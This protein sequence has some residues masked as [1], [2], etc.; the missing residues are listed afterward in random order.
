MKK[1]LFSLMMFFV[2]VSLLMAQNTDTGAQLAA[3]QSNFDRFAMQ[4]PQERVYL[5]FDN[6]SYYK[7]EHIWYKAYVV[8]D[9]TLKASDMSQILY[10]E[11][12]NALGYPVETQKLML[13][14]G[15]TSGSFL[16]K[17]SLNAGF[18]EVRAYTTWMLNFAQGN[19]HGW[20]RMQSV[21]GRDYFAERFLHYLK[22]NAGIFSRV[23][24]V[25]DKVENHQYDKKQMPAMVKLNNV[26]GKNDDDQ[27]LIDFYPEGGNL[28]RGVPTRVAFQTHT[29]EGR[30][31]NVQGTLVRDGKEIGTFKTDHAGRGV[32]SM[33]ANE[34]DEAEEELM[35]GMKLKVVY[36]GKDYK[37]SLPKSN[38]RGYVLNVFHAGDNFRATVARNAD[39]PGQLLGINITSRGKTQ[40]SGTVDL[41]N[42]EQGNV[43]VDKGSLRTGVNIFTLY[44][45]KGKVLAQ[46]Q[47]FVNNHDMDGMHLQME[48]PDAAN[49]GMK[50]Y[51]KMTLQCQVVDAEGHP[52]KGRNKFS[53][54]VTD[55]Q[56][57]DGTYADG[58]MLTYL[59]LSSEVKGFIPHPEYY[60]EKE[61]H[62]HQTALDLLLMVQGWTRYDFE[63]MMSSEK[64]EPLMVI[65]R[66]LNFRGR[67]VENHGEYPNDYMYWKKL[68]KP[69]W[70][71][72]EYATPYNG[73][74]DAEII[75]DSLGFFMFNLNP[76]FGTGRMSL[77]IN[78]K[79]AKEIG[80]RKAGVAGHNFSQWH[81]SRPWHIISK[82]IIPFNAYSPVP[83]DYDYYETKVF[84]DKIH[85]V[86]PSDVL[87]A[88]VIDVRDMM[89]Y[90]SNIFGS[91]NDFHFFGTDHDDA[92]TLI[93]KNA[94]R[95]G[96]W[97]PG[98]ERDQSVQDNFG[99]DRFF[100]QMDS[101]RQK[102]ANIKPFTLTPEEV[103]KMKSFDNRIM[104]QSEYNFDQSYMSF[105]SYGK[106]LMLY[107]LD[108]MNLTTI[109]NDFLDSPKWVFKKGSKK[110]LP[111]G[112]RFF[113]PD[114][115][116]S[117]LYVYSDN[118]D[119]SLIH[120]KGRYREVATPYTR[121][122]TN[123]DAHPLTSRFDFKTD[124]LYSVGVPEP[125]FYGYRINFQGLSEPDAFYRVD[126]S[127]EPLPE[128]A[129]CRRTIYWNPNVITDEDGRAQVTFYNNSFTK[130]VVISAE[131]LTKDGIVIHNQ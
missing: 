48:T 18:Y 123:S 105:G 41:R 77:T 118:N 114:V 6:T 90:L 12:V 59:L 42:E 75:T 106:L 3:L 54:A 107:G 100:A 69:M 8:N 112:M 102:N 131:G 32:F 7:G 91:I 60:F 26:K 38:R 95:G 78:E 16:L 116:F 22:G 70:V 73:N 65:E 11:L 36:N 4:N 84:D 74:V 119:R 127:R 62:E 47:V 110:H 9:E 89:M 68:K 103:K 13:R 53:M 1:R 56:Y 57:R 39:T 27:L 71:Y 35:R 29:K 129:D 24:P 99:D 83:R 20:Q 55:G 82:H 109:D 67:V 2:S 34:S 111:S 17:D 108:G 79:S 58:N 88:A 25:Y 101:I 85:Y 130:S 120:Q 93:G 43:V 46:R 15:Q 40:F 86:Q 63:R 50:P 94:H 113:P 72:T 14:N 66:G 21:Q 87:P 97:H 125:D 19:G 115:N 64:W 49:G 23:F 124:S 33:T 37:F 117:Q 122:A 81:R 51:E 92:F 104:S 31:V 61:D 126:Y 121:G 44:N 80:H 28:V 128:E 96:W 5:H 10:V 98:A 76:F 45:E 30:N 52:V